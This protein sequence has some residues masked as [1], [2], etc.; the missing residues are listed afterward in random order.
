[1]PVS[2]KSVTWREWLGLAAGLLALGAT[3]L[4]WTTLSTTRP[5]IEDILNSLPRGDVVRSAWSSGFFAWGP[6]L[7]LLLAGLVVAVFGRIRS[8]RV[9]GLPH[10]WLVIAAASLLMMVIGLLTLDW[11][12]DAD[13]RGL[14]DAAGIAIG[15]GIGRY[16]ALLAAIVSGVAAFFDIRAA[17]AESRRPRSRG[18]RN[19]N[20]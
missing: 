14:F 17:R 5:D 19:K 15:A 10:L 3:F 1:L 16:L 2:V 6:P 8:V 12:F 20:G 9:S 4:P 11:E 7:P 18:I 13:Q